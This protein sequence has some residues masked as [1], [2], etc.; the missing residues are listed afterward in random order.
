MSRG[1]TSASRERSSERAGSV[2]FGAGILIA[3]A[4]AVALLPERPPPPVAKASEEAPVATGPGGAGAP[5]LAPGD[6]LA[7]MQVVPGVRVTLAASEPMVASPVAAAFDEDGRLWV[8]EM[9]TYMRDLD[10]VGEQEKRNRLV[11]LRDTDGDGDFDESRVFLDD[12]ALPRGVAPCYGGAL[13]IEPPHL[14]FCKDTN[15]DG[16]A[17]MRMELLD[18]F[19]GLDNPEHAANSLVYGVD[20]WYHLSQHNVEFRF[21][22]KTVVTRPT[23]AHGQWGMTQDA[24]GRTYTTPNSDPLLLDLVPRHYGAR[25][26]NQGAVSF[27]GR[28]IVSDKSVY[29]VHPTPGVNR[30][31]QKGTLREDN[32]LRTLTAACGP[33][34]Y[35]SDALGEGFR[36]SAFVCEP[37]GNVVKR[38]VFSDKGGVPSG[39]NAYEGR[40]FLASTDE[41]F[42]PVNAITGPDGALYV[43][44]MYRGVIQHK[45]F[46]TPYLRGQ[47]ESRRLQSPVD[48]G[49]IYR[50]ARE[51][52]TGSAR[53]RLSGASNEELVRLLS[54]EDQWWRLTAQRL[55]VE[56]GAVEAAEAVRAVSRDGSSEVARL[57]A[58]WTLDGIGTITKGDVEAALADAAAPVRMAGVRLAERFL[59]DP[60]IVER[61]EQFTRSGEKWERVQAVCTLGELPGSQRVPLLGAVLREHGGDRELR[62][63]AVSGL[64]GLEAATIRELTQDQKWGAG[65]EARGVLNTLAD[66]LLRGTPEARLELVELTASLASDLNPAAEALVGRIRVAQRLDSDKPR[67]ILLARAPKRW[68]SAMGERLNTLS[69]SMGEA[70]VYFDWPDRPPVRRVQGTRPL[71][72]SELAQFERG[73]AVY[74]QACVS[75]HQGNG[76]GASGLAP[77]LVAS[78]IAEG[79]AERLASVLIH[80]LEGTWK[81]GELTYEAAMPPTPLRDD[82]DIAAVMTFIRRSFGNAG[83]PVKVEEVTAA[84]AAHRD[85]GKPWT[86][87]EVEGGVE[88]WGVG[89]R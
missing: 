21:D 72:T 42:R 80:G 46:L 74:K 3:A 77:T 66:C 78:P 4:C 11:V 84:R 8:V 28:S 65:K 73:A 87:A 23:P 24:W 5:V 57:H 32:T 36:S 35:D 18:G 26:R 83:D 9:T 53:P 75:C 69:V 10:G 55:L 49:R 82:A 31:Y 12:L 33:A 17:D 59:A 14:V 56:R 7:S 64:G 79:P 47:I 68:Q 45:L 76:R 13:V 37:A 71:T 88:A 89:R 52:E 58:L 41:R 60:G 30:G 85:R 67:P 34:W 61:I 50:I 70:E 19:T 62:D 39:S 16:R 2:A 43:L 86:R 63:A 27:L 25:N 51:G 81:M 48:C 54:H 22:G 44:D 38:Y 20:N 29:P 6:A 40:E 15:G 1:S